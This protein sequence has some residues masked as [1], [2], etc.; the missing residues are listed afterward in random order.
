MNFFTFST[1]FHSNITLI[2]FFFLFYFIFGVNN[3]SYYDILGIS[4]NA[5]ENQIQKAFRKFAIEFHPDKNKGN[6]EWAQINFIRI[7]EGYC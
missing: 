2:F 4:S 3:K 1:R 7:V 5:D 6:E